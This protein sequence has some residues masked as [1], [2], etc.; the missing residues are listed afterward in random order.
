MTRLWHRRRI[1]QV[2]V[3]VQLC[4][5]AASVT[6]ATQL[7]SASVECTCAHGDAQQCPMHHAAP[8]EQ[9]PACRVRSA[10][11]V[12]TDAFAGLFGAVA[13]PESPFQVAG[14]SQTGRVTPGPPRLVD[15]LAVPFLPPPRA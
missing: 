5:V 15:V 8:V 10:A 13:V 1:A 7:A 11:N 14:L 12:Q 6:L 4:F 9:K 3:A 2:L